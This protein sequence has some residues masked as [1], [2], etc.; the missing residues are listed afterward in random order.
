MRPILLG[1]GGQEVGEVHGRQGHN[2]MVAFARGIAE[3]RGRN[4]DWAEQAVRESV[5]VTADEALAKNVIDV[6][7][8]TWTT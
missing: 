7:A 2:D 5:S 3:R 1:A 6:V 4:A 8:K